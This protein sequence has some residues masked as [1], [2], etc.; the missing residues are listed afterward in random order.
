MRVCIEEM[1][2]QYT[3]SYTSSSPM[4][5]T[6]TLLYLNHDNYLHEYGHDSDTYTHFT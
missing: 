6:F 4:M 1:I 2:A 5:L 3:P